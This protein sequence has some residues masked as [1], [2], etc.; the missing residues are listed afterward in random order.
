MKGHQWNKK[1][2]LCLRDISTCFG[3]LFPIIYTVGSSILFRVEATLLEI[4]VPVEV[5]H[6]EDALK[7]PIPII[8]NSSSTNHNYNQQLKLQCMTDTCFLT[9][10]NKKGYS[11]K[12]IIF[13]ATLQYC[14]NKSNSNRSRDLRPKAIDASLNG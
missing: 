10:T 6:S 7:T 11:S 9:L 13:F 2:P 5:C 14:P 3:V 4:H 1:C 12:D 8:A